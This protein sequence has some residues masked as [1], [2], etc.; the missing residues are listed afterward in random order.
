[1][2][3]QNAG[4]ERRKFLRV[5]EEDVT[6][7]EPFDASTLSGASRK[8]VHVI[9]KDLSQGGLL[10]ESGEAYAI[11]AIL[12]LEVGIPGWEKFKQEFFKADALSG[13]HPLVVL[14]KVVR[15]E[16]VGG[17]NYD[18][19]VVFMALDSGHKIAL[20]KYLEQAAKLS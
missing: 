12:K 16:D 14:G 4:P 5:H 20:Q 10:F 17:G 9:T 18:I 7:C 11:G 15:V 13:R 3:K 19:G 2:A 6:V 1:M 8:R